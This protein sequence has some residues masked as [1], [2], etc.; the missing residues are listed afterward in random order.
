[1]NRTPELEN[2]GEACSSVEPAGIDELDRPVDLDES[3]KP[4][5]ELDRPVDLDE[6]DRSSGPGK[7]EGITNSGGTD[8]AEVPDPVSSTKSAVWSEIPESWPL[9]GSL[10]VNT[11]TLSVFAALR[12]FLAPALIRRILPAFASFTSWSF[13]SL[14]RAVLFAIP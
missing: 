7:S 2:V 5:D 1:M 9:K 8:R 4:I 6:L 14:A 10:K 3:N 11:F 12:A 13:A